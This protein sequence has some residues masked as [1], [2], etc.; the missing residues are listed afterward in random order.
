[1]SHQ[2]HNK[3]QLTACNCYGTWKWNKEDD[4]NDVTVQSRFFR[5]G[6]VRVTA[7]VSFGVCN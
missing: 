1:M 5:A 7:Q 6:R 3:S 2:K 4:S